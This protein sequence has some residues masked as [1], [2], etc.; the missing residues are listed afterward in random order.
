M[1][2]AYIPGPHKEACLDSSLLRNFLLLA[3]SQGA[4]PWTPSN[5]LAQTF[6]LQPMAFSSAGCLLWFSVNALT[7]TFLPGLL[8]LFAC[9]S[10][11]PHDCWLNGIITEACLLQPLALS[12]YYLYQN[13]HQVLMAKTGWKLTKPL[14]LSEYIANLHFPAPH[15][16]WGHVTRSQ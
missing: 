6:T 5:Y 16:C 10:S 7:L 4:S 14:S 11:G 1:A 3:M 2:A 13:F 8:L 15:I 9:F 12:C